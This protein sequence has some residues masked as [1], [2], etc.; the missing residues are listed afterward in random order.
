[1]ADTTPPTTIVPTD[2]SPSLTS[3]PLRQMLAAP[4]TAAIQAQALAAKSTI[5]FIQHVGFTTPVQADPSAHPPTKAGPSELLNVEFNY[6]VPDNSVKPAGESKYKISAPL[7]SIIPIPYLRISD[8]SIDFTY[9]INTVQSADTTN[10]N[11]SALDTT[12]TADAGF[13]WWG[14]STTIKGSISHDTT[15]TTHSSVTQDST[16][17]VHVNA[18]QD[19]MP[20][21]LAIILSAITDAVAKSASAPATPPPT[22]IG[23]VT[24]PS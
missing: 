1:M 22:K 19:K 14:V 16:L 9:N 8:M 13:L 23:K 11:K 20:G 4:M 18:V 10:E 7:L 24:P 6:T 17:H 21:G 5:D 3:L 15:D 2:I 12:V